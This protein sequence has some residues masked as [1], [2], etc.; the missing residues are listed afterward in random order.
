RSKYPWTPV[1]VGRAL[2]KPRRVPLKVIVVFDTDCVTSPKSPIT[3]CTRRYSV[4]NSAGLS[5]R[6]SSSVQV[7]A[8][9]DVNLLRGHGAGV[10]ACLL[11]HDHGARTVVRTDRV[12]SRHGDCGCKD[13]VS[14]TFRHQGTDR[15]RCGPS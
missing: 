14:R 3:S 7:G 11:P 5:R 6:W 12:G 13:G 15:A 9:I 4:T 1:P 8:L 10:R 2:A